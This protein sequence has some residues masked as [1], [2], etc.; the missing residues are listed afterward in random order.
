MTKTKILTDENDFEYIISLK[1]RRS[2]LA[3]QKPQ[4][5]ELL[6]LYDKKIKELEPERPPIN[7]N[8]WQPGSFTEFMGAL[9]SPTKKK[10]ILHWRKRYNEKKV[11]AQKA[12]REKIIS[13][14]ERKHE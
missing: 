1:E 12:R 2:F 3:T 4:Q 13:V 7:P 9:H 14:F 8:T 10:D 5:T 6:G 11:A